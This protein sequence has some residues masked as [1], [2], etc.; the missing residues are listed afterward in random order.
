MEIAVNPDGT[1]NREFRPLIQEEWLNRN[2]SLYNPNDP[3]V[4]YGLYDGS[5][6]TCGPFTSIWAGY[7]GG[8]VASIDTYGRMRGPW[9]QPSYATLK[10]QS[11]PP[12]PRNY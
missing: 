1:R 2:L 3:N 4:N 11:V 8:P 7:R 9:Y 12:V 10:S 6:P 5:Q